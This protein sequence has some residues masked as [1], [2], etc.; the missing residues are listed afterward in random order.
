MIAR[1]PVHVWQF[2]TMVSFKTHRAFKQVANIV[3][4][5]CNSWGQQSHAG[6]SLGHN[7][8]P[9]IFRATSCINHW[10]GFVGKIY[11]KPWFLPS[12]IGLSG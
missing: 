11:R 4:S 12:N 7:S 5:F 9:Q 6:M 10:I 1:Y 8:E 2:T 3:T